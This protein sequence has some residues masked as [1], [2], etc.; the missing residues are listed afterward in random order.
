MNT[1]KK[2]MEA[3][4]SMIKNTPSF[5]SVKEKLGTYIN[6]ASTN[7]ADNLLA[8]LNMRQLAELAKKILP[9]IGQ[10]TVSSQP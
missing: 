1:P 3:I 8:F 10:Y 9:Q 6:D 5:N 2:G 4:D 7:N